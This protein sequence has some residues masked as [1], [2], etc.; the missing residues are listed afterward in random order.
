MAN[1]SEKAQKSQQGLRDATVQYQA[2][3]ERVIKDP[4]GPFIEQM[5]EAEERVAEAATRWALDYETGL[6]T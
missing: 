3:V 2:L 4:R 1:L 5:R 6:E